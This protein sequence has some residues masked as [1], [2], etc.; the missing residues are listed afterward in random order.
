MDSLY[1]YDSMNGSKIL[2][3][4]LSAEYINALSDISIVQTFPYCLTCSLSWARLATRQLSIDSPS[5]FDEILCL[6]VSV[7]FIVRRFSDSCH[8]L[9][10]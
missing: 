6:S 7:I 9:M 10:L 1:F 2:I 8:V 5:C 4:L 3:F